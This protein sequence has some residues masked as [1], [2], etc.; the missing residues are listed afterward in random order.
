MTDR[1]PL[2]LLLALA[3]L[4]YPLMILWL[5]PHAGA[6][7]LALAGLGLLL[8]RA[9]ITRKVRQNGLF[10]LPIIVLLMAGQDELGLRL[11]PV[12]GNLMMLVMFAGSLMGPM[13]LVE[14][15]ARIS[16]PDLPEAGI[17][18]TRNVTWVWTGFFA[19]NTLAALATAVWA[20]LATWTLYNGALSYLLTP[21]LFHGEWIVRQYVRRSHTA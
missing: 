10:A 21:L 12:L 17:R 9:V 5:L 16:E 14:R 3:G 4:M 1:R 20:D 18:Y 19:L 13:P 2:A 6:R 8:A 7:A 11:Y 15:L